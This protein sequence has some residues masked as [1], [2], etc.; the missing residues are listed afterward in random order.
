MSPATRLLVAGCLAMV[1]AMGIG[2]FYYT[3][4][5]P[6]MQRE[7]GFDAAVAGLIASA[8]FGGYLVGSIAASMLAPGVTRVW[9]FRLALIGSVA[10]TAAMG[11]TDSTPMWIALRTLSGIASALAMIAGAGM[12][13]EALAKIEEPGRIG[14]YFGGVGLGI[15]VSGMLAQF[16]GGGL[17]AAQMWLLAGGIGVLLLPFIFREL[18]E[19]ELEPRP[20]RASA[21]RRRPRPLRLW[22]LFVNYTC[23]GLGYSVF[24][25]FIVAIVKARP[26]TEAIGDWVWVVVGLAGLPSTVLWTA[27][28]ERFGF[29]V[30]LILAYVVQIAGVLLPAASG[31]GLAALA[32]AVMFGG[33]FLSITALTLPLGRHGAGGRGF[34]VLTAGFGAGQML[35]PV[36]A[37]YMVTLGYGFRAALYGSAAVL[38]FGLAVLIYGV[39]TRTEAPGAVAT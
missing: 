18:I 36:I 16:A 20:H 26:Q 9:V 23:E 39:V 24:A 28:A 10:T 38:A 19:R 22:P 6:L 32:A 17:S 35:G 34:A 11:L 25:T 30:S 21:G 12:V 37:G 8:N 5:L 3:P 2:R 14:W 31:S 33:T 27:L 13:A 29:T 15:L 4:M 7:Y 1:V